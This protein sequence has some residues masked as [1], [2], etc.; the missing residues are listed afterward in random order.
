[1][2]NKIV[3]IAR[4]L[5]AVPLALG[6]VGCAPKEQ[7]QNPSTPEA[8]AP[9]PQVSASASALSTADG[10]EAGAKSLLSAFVKPGAD[11]AS[12]TSQLRPTKADL[13]AI[14][15][16]GVAAKAD[17]AYSPAWDDGKMVIEPKSGQSEVKLF[18]ATSEELKSGSG[19]AEAFPGGWKEVASELKPGLQ[20]YGFKF[21][22][23]GEEMGMAFDGLVFVNDHWC[24][25]PKPW[26]VL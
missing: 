23:P 6:L 25:V 22:E 13:E 19:K 21:V 14:F 5:P 9:V 12:L 10:T 7:S 16:P 3:R 26:R 20:V 4:I 8:S 15:S 2:M 18:S 17:A 1:M 24:I 11:H